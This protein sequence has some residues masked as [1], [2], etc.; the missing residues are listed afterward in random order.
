MLLLVIIQ[1]DTGHIT[2]RTDVDTG[3]YT[4]SGVLANH[5]SHLLRP[6]FKLSKV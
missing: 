6:E 4:P 2:E 3:F 5:S 1:T